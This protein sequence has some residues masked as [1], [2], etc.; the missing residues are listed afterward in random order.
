MSAVRQPQHRIGWI[1]SDKCIILI[2]QN[3][4]VYILT[5]YDGSFGG[6]PGQIERGRRCLA[7][8]RAVMKWSWSECI[9]CHILSSTYSKIQYL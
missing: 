5:F 8:G 6:R 4:K 7:V 9:S 2:H 3:H 1:F